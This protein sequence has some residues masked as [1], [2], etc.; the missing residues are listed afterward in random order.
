MNLYEISNLENQIEQLA[1]ANDGELSEEMLQALVASETQSIVHIENLCKYIRKLELG[2]DM[3]KAEEDRI[4][5]MRKKANKRIAGIEKYLTPYVV[6]H[7]KIESGTFTLS[8]RKSESVNIINEAK[9]PLAY[10]HEIP[11]RLEPDKNA[12]KKDIKAGKSVPGAELQEN[13]NLTIK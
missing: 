6:K 1:A 13:Y 9:L 4:N 2:I 11:V 8:T 10:M 5:T 7:G 12:I 3:C